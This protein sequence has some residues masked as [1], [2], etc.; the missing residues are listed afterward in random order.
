M[1]HADVDSLREALY[2]GKMRFEHRTS[3][4]Q[5]EGTVHSLYSYREPKFGIR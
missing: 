2:S 3:A 4:A 5:A 1:G